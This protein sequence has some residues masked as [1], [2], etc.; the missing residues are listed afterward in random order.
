MR[1]Q[2]LMDEIAS[3]TDQLKDQTRIILQHENSLHHLRNESEALRESNAA[4]NQRVS[5]SLK[6]SSL[7]HVC[8]EKFTS[9]RMSL[10]RTMRK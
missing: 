2:K 8:K 6:N 7:L 9:R 3:K 1:E 10:K 5:L 4:L